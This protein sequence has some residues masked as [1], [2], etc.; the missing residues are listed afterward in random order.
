MSSIWQQN[1]S[2]YSQSPFSNCNSSTQRPSHSR[3]LSQPAFLSL[4]QNSSMSSV[5]E[6]QLFDRLPPISPASMNLS[7]RRSGMPFGA[8]VASSDMSGGNSLDASMENQNPLGVSNRSGIAISTA[9]AAHC[10]LPPSSFGSS[11]SG[12]PA[13]QG[14]RRTHSEVPYKFS[15][16]LQSSF[17]Q[18]DDFLA[19]GILKDSAGRERIRDQPFE[20]QVS[21]DGKGGFNMDDDLNMEC[22]KER[23]E[24]GNNLYNVPVEMQNRDNVKNSEGVDIG[25]V[26]DESRKQIMDAND[27]ACKGLETR[28]EKNLKA[29]DAE[30]KEKSHNIYGSSIIENECRDIMMRSADGSDG[31]HIRTDSGGSDMM[32]EKNDKDADWSSSG[33]EADSEANLIGNQNRNALP[34]ERDK[35]GNGHQSFGSTR[36]NRSMSMD[37]ILSNMNG[38]N[39]AKDLKLSP[40]QSQNSRDFRR[41]STDVNIKFK[42]ELGNGEFTEAEL[43]KI[44][45]NEKLTE[46]A[47]TDP[48]RVKRILANRLSAARSKER[49]MLYI[50]ELEGKVQTL[51]TE[52][53]TL[54]AQ[55]TLMQRDLSGLANENNGLK[56]RLQAMEQQAQL[57]DAL[58]KALM[59]EVQRLKLATGQPIAEQSSGM[60]QQM[61]L[62]SHLY[63]LQ[64]HGLQQ[65]Q[66][67]EENVQSSGQKISQNGTFQNSNNA[68]QQFMGSV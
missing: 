62:S 14:H 56:L 2:P 1:E 34:L 20:G 41:S 10:P 35:E 49:K 8:S 60:A 17:G 45:S 30:S 26:N 28:A 38:I 12:L 63:Q 48:R 32:K 11:G 64:Q 57:Q 40:S 43:K 33:D 24:L 31:I 52:A 54:S 39:S 13:R 37:S 51:Q 16:Q 9:A 25:P 58:N 18:M 47:R 7:K 44:L 22:L 66:Q 61:S 5:P 55:L 4:D 42:M 21:Q 15:Q 53:T 65:Q 29:A 68:Y 27:R 23:G 3:S 19:S 36:H 59:E 50:S 6:A 46:I 67:V